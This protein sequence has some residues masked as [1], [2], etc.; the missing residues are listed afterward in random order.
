MNLLQIARERGVAL[1]PYKGS[2]YTGLCP[3]H[4]DKNPSFFVNADKNV[5][6][7]HGCKAKGNVYQFLIQFDGVLP[8]TAY[9]M[10]GP[11][12]FLPPRR[13][14]AEPPAPVCVPA[15]A[16]APDY[17]DAYPRPRNAVD[18][19]YSTV[20]GLIAYV[21]RRIDEPTGKRFYPIAWTG[22]TW[23][24]VLPKKRLPYHL[25]HA[26]VRPQTPLM[27]VEGEKA[28]AAAERLFW[29]A[30]VPTT[31]HGGA[32]AVDKT[33]WTYF[34][35]REAVVCPDND[36]AGRAAAERLTALLQSMDCVVWTAFPPSE[37]PRGWDWADF[38]G[39]STQAYTLLNQIKKP[40]PQR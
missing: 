24:S 7:C 3:F 21:I 38:N 23:D 25:W 8:R 32:H 14:A 28:A 33:D 26:A 20:D 2:E 12:V 16:D 17:Q 10:A 29:D 11:R 5:Y 22:S 6:Y 9:R 35:G 31:W 34:A 15:P 36:A 40:A 4:A 37:F 27:I 13:A 30:Y 19:V 39:D 18:Y 1:T